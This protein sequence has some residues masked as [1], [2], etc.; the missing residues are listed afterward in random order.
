[1]TEDIL[2]LK[3]TWGLSEQIPSFLK[4]AE[5]LS[6]LTTQEAFVDGVDQHQTTQNVQPDL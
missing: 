6:L 2:H 5:T 4:F 3:I 1:M